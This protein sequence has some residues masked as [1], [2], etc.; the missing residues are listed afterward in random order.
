[1]PE[2]ELR[3]FQDWDNPRDPGEWVVFC[4]CGYESHSFPRKRDAEED[5]TEHHASA[6]P[7]ND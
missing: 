2:T 3:F 4:D 5:E 6:H 7:R 1:M